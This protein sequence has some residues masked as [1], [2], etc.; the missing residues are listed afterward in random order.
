MH[1]AYFAK[2]YGSTS[3]RPIYFV[4]MIAT[5]LLPLVFYG[6]IVNVLAGSLILG[7]IAIISAEEGLR[8]YMKVENVHAALLVPL[9]IWLTHITYGA[10]FFRGLLLSKDSSVLF[11]KE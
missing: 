5:F 3:R 10:A 1:R 8:F 4:P 9:A 11:Y 6:M 2:E 7:L